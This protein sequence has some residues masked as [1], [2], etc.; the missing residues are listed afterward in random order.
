MLPTELV[1][2][3]KVQYSCNKVL[4]LIL[5][6]VEQ[7]TMNNFVELLTISNIIKKW[8]L[9]TRPGQ[10]IDLYK[11]LRNGY[12]MHYYSYLFSVAALGESEK[13]RTFGDVVRG[14][15]ENSCSLSW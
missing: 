2:Q 7:K 3:K 12:I 13:G 14:V 8:R 1:P 4:Q 10:P 11:R 6:T 15:S 5:L 9:L